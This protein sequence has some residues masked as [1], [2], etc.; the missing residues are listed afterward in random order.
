MCLLGIVMTEEQIEWLKNNLSFHV[1]NEPN[2]DY[3]SKKVSFT[4]SLK[5]AGEEISSDGFTVDGADLTSD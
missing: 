1:D 5:L 2:W 4:V 3:Y